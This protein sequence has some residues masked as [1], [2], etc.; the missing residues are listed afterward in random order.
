MIVQR[1]SPGNIHC[2]LFVH[3]I[4]CHESDFLIPQSS[5]VPL[6]QFIIF[7]IFF[8]FKIKLS[9]PFCIKNL[10]KPQKKK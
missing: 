7:P 8:C 1:V 3:C 2:G 9:S 5:P 6:V 10:N 4:L